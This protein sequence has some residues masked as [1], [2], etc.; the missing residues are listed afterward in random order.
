MN[1]LSEAIRAAQAEG[2]LPCVR[3]FDV[4]AKQKVTPLKV[5]QVT[6]RLGIWI[7]SC[8]L[9][10]F[11]CEDQGQKRLVHPAATIA[12]DLEEAIYARL[13]A[14]RLPCPTAWEL[15]EQCNLSKL[16]VANA[17]E[18]LKLRISACQLGCFD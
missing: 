14:G 6:S 2:K 16:G 1:R 17:V 12:L 5:G 15:A 9:G 13:V 11:G 10:L 7:S 8:Q 3:A 4:A 18:G